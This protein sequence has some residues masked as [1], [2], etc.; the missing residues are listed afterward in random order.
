MSKLIPYRRLKCRKFV[1]GDITPP[2]RYPV[3]TPLPPTPYGMWDGGIPY[4]YYTI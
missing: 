2:D 3:R 4:P 1:R